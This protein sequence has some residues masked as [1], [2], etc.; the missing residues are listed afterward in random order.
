M[1]AVP[2]SNL[3]EMLEKI[4]AATS[5]KTEVRQVAV[6]WFNRLY[7]S[8]RTW[9]ESFIQFL[10]GYPGFKKGSTAA[11]YAE[12]LKSLE[13][14]RDSLEERYSP[15]KND[16]CTDLKILSARFTKDFRWLLEEDPSTFHQLRGM[17][18]QSYA[19]EGMVIHV[20]H[21]ICNFIYDLSQDPQWHIRSHPDVVNKIKEYETVSR[22]AVQKLHDLA[23]Q[24]GITLLSVDEYEEALTRD[25]SKNPRIMVIGEQTVHI[26]EV[27]SMTY[28]E[29]VIN[30]GNNNTINAPIAIADHIENSF[31]AVGASKVGDDVKM[32]LQDLI[33]HINEVAKSAPKEVGQEMARD[34][35][36]LAKE[37]VSPTPRRKWYELSIDGL[38]EAA[39]KIGDLGKP[40]LETTGKLLPLLLNLFP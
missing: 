30:I 19:T 39:V 13:G 40:I 25:G 31:N 18:D 9:N 26:K 6:R 23:T 22:E 11:D 16:L 20:A 1:P 10:Y 3:K 7:Y 5:G 33:K 36:T 21:T 29:R 28:Q 17:I 27:R 37:V 32:L 12:F 2:E 35:E 4:V 34:V 8:V 15:V 24:V 38:K 14:Y